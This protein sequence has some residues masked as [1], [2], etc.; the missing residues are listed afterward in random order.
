[1]LANVYLKIIELKLKNEKP[2]NEKGEN[3]QEQLNDLRTSVKQ[4]KESGLLMSDTPLYLIVNDDTVG[5]YKSLLT[6]I[7]KKIGK[8]DNNFKNFN[9]DLK[10]KF[11]EYVSIP[12]DIL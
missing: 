11:I 5:N 4:F 8:I 3:V 12:N 9:N 6:L 1:M 2:E 7:Y 10:S